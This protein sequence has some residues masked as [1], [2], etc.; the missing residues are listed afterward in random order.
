MLRHKNKYPSGDRKD[1]VVLSN[2]IK[3]TR[4]R[5]SRQAII[6]PAHCL[7]PDGLLRPF[8]DRSSQ[9]MCSNKN[10]LINASAL[11]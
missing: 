11:M 3:V 7:S 4:H 5:L 8:N 6:Y 1:R 10:I 2:L 9:E